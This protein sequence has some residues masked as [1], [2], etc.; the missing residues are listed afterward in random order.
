MSTILFY[1]FI[2][3]SSTFFVWLSEKMLY[4][5]DRCLVIGVAFFLVFLP[6]AIRYDI[7]TD[8]L[9][10]LE[11][12]ESGS[13][14]DYKLKEPAFYFINWFLDSIG[15]HFQWLFVVFSFIFTAVAFKAYP[16]KNVWLLHFLFFSMLWYFSFNGIR[17]AMALS[18]CLLALFQFFDRKY[19]FFIVLTLIASTFHQSALIF[20]LVGIACMVP[21]NDRIKTYLA[22]L[23]FIGFI[24]FTFVAMNVVLTYMEQ[25]LQL[26][27]LTKYA[28]Y[29]NS[30][31]HF[32]AR[33]FGS[34]IGV[35]AKILFSCYVIF[36]AKNFIEINKQYWFL[37]VLVFAYA[38]ATVLANNIIIFG[39]MADVFI[40]A[41]IASSY[42]LLQLPKNRQVHKLVLACFIAFLL[43]SFIKEGFGV[44][45]S[46]ADP[47]RNPYQTIFEVKIE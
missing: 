24:A 1:N 16:R 25:I 20:T 9:N 13:Y 37:I 32:I 29:F 19:V 46:Y 15:A 40:L 47:K 39:R 2:L 8:Y 42:L 22:P 26:L 23:V 4:K 33:D 30:A 5:L 28:G 3:L 11:I 12:Y 18:W 6:A 38:V 36:N 31:K 14:I 17:Q 27:G 7:G 35:L 41:P 21:L 45:T 10:Y 43:L 34:G 44:A